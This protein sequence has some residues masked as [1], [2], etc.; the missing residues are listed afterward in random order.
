MGSVLAFK[1]A[2]ERNLRKKVIFGS[3]FPAHEPSIELEKLALIFSQDDLAL[4]GRA[5]AQSILGI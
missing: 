1:C 5:N 2:K 4:I 3:E